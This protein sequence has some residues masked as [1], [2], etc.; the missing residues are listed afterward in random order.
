[1]EVLSA[2]LIVS[3]I[4]VFPVD[5]GKFNV[6]TQPVEKITFTSGG[7][8]LNVA[9]NLAEL[10]VEA[11]I[12]G[13]IGNDLAGEGILSTIKSAG[14][15]YEYLARSKKH[16]TSS[17]V[18]LC[19][20]SGEHHFVYYG[21]S[22]DEFSSSMISDSVLS[23]IKILHIG[24]AMALA[25]LDGKGLEELFLRAKKYGVTTTLDAAHDVH[26]K[27]LEKVE[28]AFENTDIFF[29]SYDE[30]RMITGFEEPVKMAEFMKKYGLKIFGVKLG[31]KGCYVTNFKDKGG[32]II[33]AFNCDNIVDT[34]GAGDAF[35]AGF[36]CGLLKDFDY[37]DC[38]LMGSAVSNF[39]IRHIGATGHLPGFENVKYL[40]FRNKKDDY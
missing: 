3:D 17:A 22:N 2:G 8:A 21:K 13:V 6:D 5:F 1:M 34:T 23:Q 27:W 24:S 12:A 18:V 15:N 28:R 4:V 20:K 19:Q 31:V 39:C 33:P 37:I 36:I 30:A 14:L 7:D 32:K 38:A 16:Q 35:M 26:G 25:E 9:V 29:P 10:G 11:G 40:A